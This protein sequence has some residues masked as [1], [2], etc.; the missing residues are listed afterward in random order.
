[1][2]CS[3]ACA[4]RSVAITALGCNAAPSHM[5]AMQSNPGP[6]PPPEAGLFITGP[7]RSNNAHCLCDTW[8]GIQHALG[9]LVKSN[10]GHQPMEAW[11]LM[12]L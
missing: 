3:P 6:G 7:I 8:C 4:F 12:I 5:V 9:V 1:M 2:R 11:I 10:L